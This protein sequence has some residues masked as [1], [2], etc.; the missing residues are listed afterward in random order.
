[1]KKLQR[2]LDSTGSIP[3]PLRARARLE[4][5][6]FIRDRAGDL[7]HLMSPTLK[8]LRF[9]IRDTDGYYLLQLDLDPEPLFHRA[10]P[11]GLSDLDEGSETS[12]LSPHQ[13]DSAKAGKTASPGQKAFPQLQTIQECDVCEVAPAATG[14]SRGAGPPTG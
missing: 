13:G 1:V 14:D 8:V 2:M 6:E 7:T 12:Y 5:G 9:K 4:I 3:P 10:G 11:E